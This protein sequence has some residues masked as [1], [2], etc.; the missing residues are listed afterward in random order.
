M[1]WCAGD[2]STKLLEELMQEAGGSGEPTVSRI[3]AALLKFQGVK[4]SYSDAGALRPP[5]SCQR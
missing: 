3:I 2:G 1:G 5:A 4:V